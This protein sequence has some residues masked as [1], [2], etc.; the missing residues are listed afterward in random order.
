MR[1]E[2]KKIGINLIANSVSYTT[3]I[4]ISFILTPYLINNLGK[5]AYSFYPLANNF[6]SYMSIITVAL[7]SIGSRFITVEIAKNRIDNAAKYFSSVYYS[8]LILSAILLIPMIIIIIFLDVILQIPIELVSSIKL[9]FGLTFVSMIVNVTSSVFGTATFAKNRIDLRSYGEI[10]QSLVK[11]ILYILLFSCF[12]PNII[13]VGIVAVAVSI[14]RMGMNYYFSRKLLPEIHV[15]IKL[16]DVNATKKIFTSSIWSSV[17]QVGSIFLL[18]LNI[19]YA[20]VFVNSS[21]GGDY[22]IIQVVPSFINGIISMLS[23]V[24]LPEIT[25]IYALGNKEDLIE[26]VKKTQ[27]IMGLIASV[28]ISVFLVVGGDFFRLWVPNENSMRLQLLSILTIVHLLFICV[29]WTVSNLN[30]VLN[31]VKIPGVFMLIVGLF[32]FILVYYFTKY[33]NFGVY[34]IS[35][36][37]LPLLLIWSAIFIPIYPSICLKVSKWTF[38]PEVFKTVFSSSIIIF[39]SIVIKNFIMIDTWLSLF[40]FCFICCFIGI[41]INYFIILTR[42]ERILIYKYCK[43]IIN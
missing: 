37:S 35:L 14:I 12:S 13:Y 34:A 7:E 21:A 16:F 31:R 38:Y 42:K 30:T 23:S 10:V 32:N 15:S 6:V 9:L 43:S 27:R 20:N 24:F 29:T 39:I 5:E 8:N 40:T 17:Y 18:S 22:S 25:R 28:P 36:A 19:F 33:T 41:I 3:T 1:N 2:S 26:V 4:I 11:V